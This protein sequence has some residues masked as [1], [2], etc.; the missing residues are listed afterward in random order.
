MNS[1][2][3]LARLIRPTPEIARWQGSGKSDGILT[4]RCGCDINAG[5]YRESGAAGREA[6]A[7]AGCLDH[8]IAGH[9]HD[10]GAPIELLRLVFEKIGAGEGVAICFDKTAAWIA[11]NRRV[12]PS[13]FLD[14]H[15][16][17]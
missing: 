5:L 7:T 14:R 15:A 4:G 11:G 8:V 2:A 1:K 17:R 16:G 13:E 9:L 3:Q 6:N 12:A 10:V